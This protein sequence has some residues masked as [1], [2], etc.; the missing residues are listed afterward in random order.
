MLI[1]LVVEN[2]YSF[3]EESIFSMVA[4]SIPEH[5]GTV[6]Q[7]N[8][9]PLCKVSAIYGANA[10]GKSNL[11][12]SLALI[13]EGV[14]LEKGMEQE[15]L[16]RIKPFHLDARM[17]LEDTLLETSFILEGVLYRYGFYVNR[18]E[19]TEEYLYEEG[20]TS[21]PHFRRT[22]ED[23]LVEGT[24]LPFIDS[25][26]LTS[27]RLLLADLFRN[28]PELP[29]I[30]FIKAWFENTQIIMDTNAVSLTNLKAKLH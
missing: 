15:W 5:P 21:I 4:S 22:K 16:N 8:I 18:S 14:L 11:L 19:I 12:K 30:S 24:W 3:R 20:D 28:I 1:E 17:E 26:K 27:N 25:D 23:G 10:S 13:Q 7:T 6:S 29:A 2:F 9:F